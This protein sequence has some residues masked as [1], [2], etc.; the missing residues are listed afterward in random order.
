MWSSGFKSKNVHTVPVIDWCLGT[1]TVVSS[2]CQQYVS[3]WTR[4]RPFRLHGYQCGNSSVSRASSPWRGGIVV[5]SSHHEYFDICLTHKL[6]EC[7][8]WKRIVN[9]A[10]RWEQNSSASVR[11]ERSI[12]RLH[13]TSLKSKRSNNQ[14][15]PPFVCLPVLSRFKRS[16]LCFE[17][18]S[19]HSR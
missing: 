9:M 15:P 14:P 6:W 3:H 13:G 11:V 1:V 17:N 18:Y 7:V 5:P 10:Y 2:Q 8:I 19:S 16:H 4:T 12:C